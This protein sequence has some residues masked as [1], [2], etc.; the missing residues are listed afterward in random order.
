MGKKKRNKSKL[1]QKE[2]FGSAEFYC[3][4]CDYTF[5]IDWETI[6]DIQE[7]THG[8]VGYHLNDTFICCEKCGEFI[9]DKETV[10]VK[11]PSKKPSQFIMD[12]EL[13]F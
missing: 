11:N 2:D 5:E 13:P 9:E 3:A 7:C 8:Y 1:K 12:D 4:K 6:W 10:G